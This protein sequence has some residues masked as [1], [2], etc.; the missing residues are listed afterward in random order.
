MPFKK[1]SPSSGSPDCEP[2]PHVYLDTQ[3]IVSDN[4]YA[5][6][7]SNRANEPPL[8]EQ[9]EPIAV[10]GMGGISMTAIRP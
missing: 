10:I 9:L 2:S 8:S 3:R 4:E 1:D 6:G 5:G 7:F